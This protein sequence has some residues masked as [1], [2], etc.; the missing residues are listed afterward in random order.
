MFLKEFRLPSPALL[1]L[2]L[3]QNKSIMA[4]ENNVINLQ[5]IN[6]IATGT[7]IT[8]DLLSDGDIRIDGELMGD[9]ETRG[10]L[11]I[12]ASGRVEG[13]IR[14]KSCEIAGTL[15]GKLF[16]AEL[17]SLKA[18]SSVSGD[19][20]TGKLTIE[21]GAFFMGTCTMGDET[22]NNESR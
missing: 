2:K 20:V 16:I 10:R 12:G 11:V 19:M 15:K 18:S 14:C 8:G 1:S 6:L 9:L 17:L 13:E 21:P 3:V 7:K 5:V 4:K 22:T